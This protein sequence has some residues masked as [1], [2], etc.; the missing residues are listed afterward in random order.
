MSVI[1]RLDYCAAAGATR[2]GHDGEY[3]GEPQ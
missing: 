1:G 2:A 3:G